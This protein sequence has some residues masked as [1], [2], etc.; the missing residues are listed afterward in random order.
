MNEITP[1]LRNLYETVSRQLEEIKT[2]NKKTPKD[3]EEIALK[4]REQSK[5][6]RE[7]VRYNIDNH[8][9]L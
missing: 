3:I 7:I 1:S 6:F 4:S 8:L 5:D 9:K 2:K